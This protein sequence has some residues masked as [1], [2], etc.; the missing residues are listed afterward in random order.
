[1][2]RIVSNRPNE[3]RSYDGT[4]AGVRRS[5][6][7]HG[8]AELPDRCSHHEWMHAN[9]QMAK[10]LQAVGDLLRLGSEQL[11]QLT[12]KEGAILDAIVRS[13]L[14]APVTGPDLF[15]TEHLASSRYE[16]DKDTGRVLRR[17]RHMEL[18]D[19]VARRG[20]IL[21]R[22]RESVPSGT[23][24]RLLTHR[25]RKLLIAFSWECIELALND[26]CP[27]SLD[28]GETVR[29]TGPVIAQ[30]AGV[31][32]NGEAARTLA[33]L[34]SPRFRVLSYERRKG[35]RVDQWPTDAEVAAHWSVVAGGSQPSKSRGEHIR[36]CVLRQ[37]ASATRG[38][39]GPI[40]RRDFIRDRTL[41][42]GFRANRL[43]LHRLRL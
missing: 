35:F 11:P 15:K 32:Y 24:W 17:L 14:D 29:L 10:R 20:Y 18:V 3:G 40:R 12:Q 26:G 25:Q 9:P 7:E 37:I 41:R 2:P 30:L 8:L 21:R 23:S 13:D 43:V 19:H 36:E 31:D 1:M 5:L 22:D 28:R 42:S 6:A 39:V 34:A 33:D 16:Y 27:V 38:V 4:E